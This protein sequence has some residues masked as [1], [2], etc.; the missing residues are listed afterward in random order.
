MATPASPSSKAI[1]AMPSASAR[2]RAASTSA[3]EISRPVTAPSG[4]TARAICRLVHPPPQP[5]SI[6]LSP[7]R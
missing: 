4:P 2:E 7:G 1:L 3:G 6:T 5:M